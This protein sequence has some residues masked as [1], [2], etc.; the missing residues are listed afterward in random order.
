M[1]LN[2]LNG[3]LKPL[4]RKF[5]EDALHNFI[6]IARDCYSETGR[7][8]MARDLSR[9]NREIRK[10]LLSQKLTKIEIGELMGI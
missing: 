3:R 9:K 5:G 8:P 1:N 2:G 10:A 6:T 4:V 7:L